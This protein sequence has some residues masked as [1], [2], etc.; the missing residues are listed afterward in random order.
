MSEKLTAAELEKMAD[1]LLAEDTAKTEEAPK[2]KGKLESSDL[3]EVLDELDLDTEQMDR[4]YDVME[5]LGI[6]TV[7]ED[8]I[9]DLPD[10]IDPPMEA[11]EDIPEEE[12]VDPNS[13]VDSFG[14]DDPVRMYLKEI[15]K[16][17]LLSADEEIELATIMSA[18]NEAK[19]RLSAAEG[20]GAHLTEEEIA[21]SV[22]IINYIAQQPLIKATFA[23]HYH[24]NATESI[25]GKTT[26]IL[27][28]LFKGIVGEIYID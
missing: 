9:P 11:M 19:E 10:D 27:G 24:F 4:I 6:D 26:Y 20:V 7:S 13:M 21:A 12:V 28:G 16:V 17:S 5:N 1:Q 25:N 18:G 14:T 3:S 15:G 8:Y 2:K 23:G 22:D